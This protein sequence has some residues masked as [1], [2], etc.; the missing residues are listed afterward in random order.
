MENY[1]LTI[2]PQRITNQPFIIELNELWFSRTENPILTAIN[3]GAS[4][5][6]AINDDKTVSLLIEDKNTL[7]L[8]KYVEDA[9]N[10]IQ[11]YVE[12]FLLRF[13]N[14]IDTFQL[15]DIIKLVERHRCSLEQGILY[16]QNDI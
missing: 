7:E 11:K 14:E 12:A 8:F 5:V 3:N 16:V 1:E 6:F 15:G 4:L 10:F 13:K 2:I 9:T